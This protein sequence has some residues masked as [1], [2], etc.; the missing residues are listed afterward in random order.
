MGSIAPLHRRDSTQR[1]ERGKETM[2]TAERRA[3]RCEE[4]WA[5]FLT[6]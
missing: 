4:V 6:C 5:A 3:Q 2:L 1:E